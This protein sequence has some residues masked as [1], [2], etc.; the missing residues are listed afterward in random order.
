M[1][2]VV[3]NGKG[4]LSMQHLVGTIRGH[5]HHRSFYVGILT[6]DN[7]FGSS[8]SGHAATIGSGPR[9]RTA[10]RLAVP[11]AAPASGYLSRSLVW[12]GSW[13]RP[14]APCVCGAAKWSRLGVN[15]DAASADEINV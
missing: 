13:R 3:S 2:I 12:E 11:L 4:L 5:D 9:A 14:N 1:M 10:W 15:A 8:G 7:V 6:Y